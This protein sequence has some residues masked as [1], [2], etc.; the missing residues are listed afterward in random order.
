MAEFFEVHTTIGGREQAAE[1]AH[2]ILFSGLATSIDIAEAPGREATAWQLTFIA[3]GPQVAALERH[4]R[5]ASPDAPVAA[6][7]VTHD[8]D[9]YPDWLTDGQA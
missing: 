8:I 1:L 5:R 6:E 2:G 4:I 9:S 3:A 7:P